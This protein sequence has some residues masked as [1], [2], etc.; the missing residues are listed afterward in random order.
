MKSFTILAKESLLK[1]KDGQAFDHCLKQDTLAFYHDDYRSGRYIQPL[2]IENMIVTIK[3]NGFY[4]SPEIGPVCPLVE[5]IIR[6]DL[7]DLINRNT[8]NAL[9]VRVCVIPR[10]KVD[11]YYYKG[12]YEGDPTLLRR[13]VSNAIKEIQEYE[14]GTFDIC[15][16][17]NTRTTHSNKNGFGGDGELPYCGITKDTCFINEQIVGKEILLID[18]LYTKTVGID[19]DAIQALYDNGAKKVIFYSLGRTIYKNY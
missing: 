11:N 16:H 1:T 9:P 3:N 17:T 2:T 8:F 10:S 15:R 18:D 12:C 6:K 19:E 14:D 7:I 13:I 5:S 4:N